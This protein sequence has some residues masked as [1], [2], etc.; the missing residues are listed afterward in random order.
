M[1]TCCS[2]PS[3]GLYKLYSYIRFDI[4]SGEK[5]FQ[6]SLT[7]K[8]DLWKEETLKFNSLNFHLKEYLGCAVVVRV[9]ESANIIISKFP[10]E[11]SWENKINNDPSPQNTFGEFFF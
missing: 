10:Y 9:H 8:L 4:K 11:K 1:F 6:I 7:N 3:D 2:H 5:H